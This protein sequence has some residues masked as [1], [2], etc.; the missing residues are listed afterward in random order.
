MK[1]KALHGSHMH[2]RTILPQ[3]TTVYVMRDAT[4][5]GL[6]FWLLFLY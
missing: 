2:E 5:A 6:R 3:T 1:V 4:E